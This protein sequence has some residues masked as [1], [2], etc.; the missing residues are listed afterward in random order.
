MA[1]RKAL[2]RDTA[3]L[4]IEPMDS[5][6]SSRGQYSSADGHSGQVSPVGFNSNVKR[7]FG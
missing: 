6:P 5:A 7:A 2:H 3:A 4:T 1:L